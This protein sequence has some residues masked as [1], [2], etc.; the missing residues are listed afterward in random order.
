MAR[1]RT[2]T[3]P[4]EQLDESLRQLLE[5]FED[6][7]L[8]TNLP[9]RLYSEFRVNA[10]SYLGADE[11]EG[12]DIADAYL[13]LDDITRALKAARD[14]R[15]RN[16][17]STL[18]I[19]IQRLTES[20]NRVVS[21]IQ[22]SKPGHESTQASIASNQALKDVARAYGGDAE[23]E[24]VA[25]SRCNFIAAALLAAAA[26]SAFWIVQQ[27]TEGG[28][29]ETWALILGP[30]ILCIVLSLATII[31]FRQAATH[32]RAGRE[33][34]RLERGLLAIPQYL[35][36]LPPEAQH[37]VRAVMTQ[38]LFPRLLEDD[39]PIRQI[40]FPDPDTLLTAIAPETF[41][42]ADEESA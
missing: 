32:R 2:R 17:A 36:P 37:L 13:A 41:A 30:T 18:P 35:S 34:I 20:L 25:A 33:Y 15:N 19:H 4:F 12:I 8:Q 11:V 38:S 22:R 1:D 16:S 5:H 7:L 27:A 39:D 6:P 28:E 42:R 14:P 3:E 24:Y 21:S 40:N 10:A 26:A 29:K 31:V 9:P 23:T